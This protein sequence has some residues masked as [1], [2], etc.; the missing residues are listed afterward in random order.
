MRRLLAQFGNGFI[1]EVQMGQDLPQQEMMVRAKTPL[2][3]FPQ[4]GQFLT[5]SAPS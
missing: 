1:E 2:K 4:Q 5:Q 3:R